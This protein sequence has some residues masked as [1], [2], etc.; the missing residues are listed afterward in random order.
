MLID[1]IGVQTIFDIIW[2]YFYIPLYANG[3][4]IGF[5]YSNNVQQLTI[6]QSFFLVLFIRP[7]LGVQVYMAGKV[8]L[9][10]YS[11]FNHQMKHLI[12]KPQNDSFFVDPKFSETIN[13]RTNPFDGQIKNM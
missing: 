13:S 10:E 2:L 7:G 1:A 5:D 8:N 6:V 9:S 12:N 3:D 11:N 4:W